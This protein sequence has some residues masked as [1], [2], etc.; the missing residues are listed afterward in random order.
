MVLSWSVR[1]TLLADANHNRLWVVPA[2]ITQNMSHVAR[3]H[4]SSG[5]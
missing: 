5:G 1:L 4:L 3:R 2:A